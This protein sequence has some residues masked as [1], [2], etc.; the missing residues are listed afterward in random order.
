MKVSILMLTYNAP[1]Y[2]KKS[3]KTLKQNTLGV[4]Y[5][6]VVVDNAS[7]NRTKKLLTKLKTKGMIDKLIFNEKNELFAGGNNIA[8]KYA[9]SDTDFYLL[10]NSD[11]KINNKNWL[12]RLI[13]LH[14]GNGIASYGAVLSE[15]IRADGYCLLINKDIYDFHKL[16][17]EFQWWWSVTKLE[18][19]ILNEGNKIIAVKD[20]ENYIHHYGGKSGKGFQD[21]LGLYPDMN[22][23][24]SWFKDGKVEI[25][26]TYQ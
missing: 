2:V 7:K 22:K 15:P 6:L 4:D 24:K 3:I 13:D 21:A 17:E 12:K 23:I 8:A 16:D 1:R 20:H 10:L 9:S 18:A 19:E 25:L 14:P 11:V 26:D 5:E